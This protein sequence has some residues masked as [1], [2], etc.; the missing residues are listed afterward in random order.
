MILNYGND[1][2]SVIV[3][4]ALTATGNITAY[5]DRSLKENIVTIPNALSLVQRL[6][7][8]TF[9]WIADK[10]RSYGVIAQEV[11]EV[12]PEFI[13]ETVESESKD[14][15]TIKSVAYGNMV[16]LLI[17]AIKEQQTTIESLKQ[18]ILVLENIKN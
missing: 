15:K 2:T 5:S 1:F 11:E 16:S 4:S 18:R 10:K 3:Q 13:H 12:V 7:G 8:V 9:D 6:R 17:E 14:K